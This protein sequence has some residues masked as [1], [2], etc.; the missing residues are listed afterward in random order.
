MSMGVLPS[1]STGRRGHRDSERAPHNM[2]L[3]GVAM[4]RNEA[5]VIEAFVR[6]NLG[7]LDGLAIADHGSLDGTSEILASLQAEGLPLRVGKAA[8]AAFFQSRHMTGL[9]REALSGANTD[10]LFAPDPPDFLKS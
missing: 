9:A 3:F 1:K 6:H 10:F 4:V 5:D 7:V 8:E 2:H